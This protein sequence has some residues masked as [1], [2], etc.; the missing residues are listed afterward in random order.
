VLRVSILLVAI[1]VGSVQADEDPT[2][3]ARQLFDSGRRHFDLAEYDA[4]LA[5]FK[6]AY[7]IKD[8]PVFLYNIALC[9]RLLGQKTEAL[10]LFKNYLQ[11]RP[12][13]P[14]RED[15]ERRIAALDEEIASEARARAAAE[16]ERMAAAQS[17]TVSLTSRPTEKPPLYKRWWLWTAVGGVV[18]V[19]LAVGLGVG[20]GE[21]AASS[22]R[23]TFPKVQY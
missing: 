7:R 13:A 6:E 17:E 12:D 19:G 20:L 21:S 22:G 14:N 11:R 15:I 10:R 1:L 2:V 5:D 16:M 4:A 3:Q 8:D 23:Y 9:H 18:V